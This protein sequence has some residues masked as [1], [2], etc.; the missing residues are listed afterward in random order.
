MGRD[1]TPRPCGDQENLPLVE[2]GCANLVAH[3]SNVR[4]H[5]VR[6]VVAINRFGTDTEAELELVRRI[7]L[8]HGAEAAVVAEHHAKGG[9]GATALGE[10][11]IEA[12]KARGV[13]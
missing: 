9:A 12:C 6:A 4:K 5:G 13:S 7:A 10:A 2:K 11:V 1:L 8:A 3:I